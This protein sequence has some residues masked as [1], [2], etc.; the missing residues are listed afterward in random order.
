[1]KEK[2]DLS[3]IINFNEKGDCSTMFVLGLH[4]YDEKINYNDMVSPCFMVCYRHY[5]ELYCMGMF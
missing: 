1:M 3:Q 4:W 2:N 5:F